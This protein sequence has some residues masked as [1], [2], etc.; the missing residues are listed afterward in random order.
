LIKSEEDSLEIALKW[1]EGFPAENS[2]FQD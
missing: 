1:L 2:D